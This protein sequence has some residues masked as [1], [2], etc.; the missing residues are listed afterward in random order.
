MQARWFEAEHD[1]LHQSMEAHLEGLDDDNHDY[2]DNKA[3]GDSLVW[4]PPI[5]R[6]RPI[7]R[8]LTGPSNER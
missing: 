6:R 5:H 2:E 1:A 3:Y 4:N 8:S 7:R